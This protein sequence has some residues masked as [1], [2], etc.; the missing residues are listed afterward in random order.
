[1]KFITNLVFSII[2]LISFNAHAVESYIDLNY[3]ALKNT[4][5]SLKSEPTSAQLR[6]GVKLNSNISM[7]VHYGASISDDNYTSTFSEEVTELTGFYFNGSHSINPI[8]TA[9]IKIGFSAITHESQTGNEADDSGLSTGLGL[10]FKLNSSS[11]LIIEFLQLPDTET[12]S[13]DIKTDAL[14]IGYRST[15]EDM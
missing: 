11:S 1:M 10:N 14:L 7:E 13:A 2:L 8:T 15:F 9:Y 6:Y 3:L 12:T 4:F 5:G